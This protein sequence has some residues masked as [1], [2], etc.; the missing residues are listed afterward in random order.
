MNSAPQTFELN[1]RMS[2]APFVQPKAGGQALHGQLSE[3]LQ[4][5]DLHDYILHDHIFKNTRSEEY[6]NKPLMSLIL[7][8]TTDKRDVVP[9]QHSWF[10]Y[11]HPLIFQV[12][13]WL[14]TLETQRITGTVEQTIE[15]EQCSSTSIQLVQL[16]THP[17]I[18]V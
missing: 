3:G 12:F 18:R 6:I 4:H 15:S 2:Q 10:N 8:F 17:N 1:R 7:R 14:E 5:G 16:P 11:L 13:L 9:P